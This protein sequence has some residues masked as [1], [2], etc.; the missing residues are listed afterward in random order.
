MSRRLIDTKR[1]S[2]SQI[3]ESSCLRESIW[4][5]WENQRRTNEL[6]RALNATLYVL[7]SKRNYVCRV[8]TLS[9]RTF[10]ILLRVRPRILIVQNPSIVLATL[11]CLL[12]GIFRYFLIVDR[13]SNF[14]IEK[15]PYRS[16]KEKLF[17]I[18]SR[19]T[20]RT[21]DLTIVTNEFLK[22]L[23]EKWQG[24]GFILPDKLPQLDFA[25]KIRLDGTY[26][27]TFACSFSGDEPVEQVIEAARLLDPSIFIYITGDHRKISHKTIADAPRNVRF[28]GFLDEKL[29]QSLLLS[30]DV[31]M[32]LTTA[33]HFLLC[34]AYEGVTLGRPLILSDTPDLREYFH[35]GSVYSQNDAKSLARSAREALAEREYLENEM[36]VLRQELTCSWDDR[37]DKLLAEIERYR[38]G[39]KTLG[40]RM[41]NC[42]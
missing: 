38:S 10:L 18:L 28:T 11:A 19:Y 15:A 7:I 3:R 23:V 33:D 9:I 26:N 1:L 34:A 13:H 35:K 30:S 22:N 6:A 29:Y 8:F 40:N 42:N 41:Q 25:R 21:A 24:R 27:I 4:I 32:A 31:V 14:R 17:Q 37:F 12:K 2:F 16:I 39:K 20:I 36:L 5:T